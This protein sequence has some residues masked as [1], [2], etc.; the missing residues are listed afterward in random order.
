MTTS[1]RQ[2]TPLGQARVEAQRERILLS[3]QSCF[4]EIGLNSTSVANIA[5]AAEMSPGL[6]YR[7]F[8]SKAEITRAVVQ[9]QLALTLARFETEHDATGIAQRLTDAFA[10]PYDPLLD[11]LH[12]IL[13]LEVTA[14]AAR[15][16]VIA[17]AFRDYEEALRGYFHRGLS[18]SK[19]EGGFGLSDDL[20]AERGLII[21]LLYQGL[22]MRQ[23]HSP[24]LD[25]TLLFRALST[26]V[27]RIFN[28]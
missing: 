4:I 20:A 2:K 10:R 21:E 22:K 5:E 16:P 28:S 24:D 8:E 1:A 9:R 23:V 25:K 17:Q 14:E 13:L 19:E 26:V 6:I 3:A 11:E 15:D 27:N 18:R 12:P 7:Y